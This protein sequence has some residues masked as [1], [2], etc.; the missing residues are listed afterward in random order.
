MCGWAQT[1]IAHQ[2]RIV[3]MKKRILVAFCA[4]AVSSFAFSQQKDVKADKVLHEVIDK[5]A[6]MKTFSGSFDLTQGLTGQ[7]PVKMS[8]T[9]L[10]EKPRKYAINFTGLID[11]RFDCDGKSVLAYFK[12]QNAYFLVPL[13]DYALSMTATS[14]PPLTFFFNQHKLVA[15]GTTSKYLG[16]ETFNGE[17]CDLIEQ[18]LGTATIHLDI[19]PQR[20]IVHLTVHSEQAGQKMDVEASIRSARVNQPTQEGSFDTAPIKGA[21]NVPM[22]R[23]DANSPTEGQQAPDFELPSMPGKTLKLSE[24]LKSHKA[25]LIDFWFVACATCREE[26][27]KLNALYLRAKKQGLEI[28]AIDSMDDLSSVQAYAK[29]AGISFPIALDDRGEMH[30][31]IAKKYGVGLYPTSFLVDQTGKVSAKFE[32][33]KVEDIEKALA[34]LGI[35][36]KP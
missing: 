27:P 8:G 21:T 29:E 12:G 33:N 35:S 19:N 15:P 32:G 14:V 22:P 9:F 31:G 25:V 11:M 6:E 30:Y 28:V 34:V 10:A 4:L 18:Q 5:Y 3:N 1:P 7:A 17:K 26:F 16:E 23:A 36:S 24:I 13:D 2:S 20:L